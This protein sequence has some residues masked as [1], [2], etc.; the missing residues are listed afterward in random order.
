MYECSD[1]EAEGDGESIFMN[2]IL[3]YVTVRIIAK[4]EKEKAGMPEYFSELTLQRS[5]T[6]RLLIAL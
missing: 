5:L 3:M 4:E 6:L 1:E 2:M